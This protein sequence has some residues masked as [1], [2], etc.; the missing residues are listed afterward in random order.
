[1]AELNMNIALRIDF[2]LGLRILSAIVSMTVLFIWKIDSN[3]YSS[4]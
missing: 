3:V 1:M 4:V 2:E